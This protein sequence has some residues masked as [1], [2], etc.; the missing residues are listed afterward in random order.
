MVALF[1]VDNPLELNVLLRA[2]F[3]AKFYDHADGPE[4]A[5]SPFMSRLCERAM[6]SFA[7]AQDAGLLPGN[8]E[9]MRSKHPDARVVACVRSHVAAIAAGEGNWPQWSADERANCVREL[10]RPY[11][12]DES[13]VRE[14]ADCV[15]DSEPRPVAD[16]GA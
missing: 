7:N 4:L 9:R 3:S 12:A 2:L 15:P 11:V 6:E 14:L 5:G 10:F 8:S 13:L 1:T 16:G